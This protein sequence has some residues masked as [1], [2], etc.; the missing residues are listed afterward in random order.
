MSMMIDWMIRS[1]RILWAFNIKY[2]IIK[3]GQEL[4]TRRKPAYG[5]GAGRIGGH[6]VPANSP[7]RLNL[8]ERFET[9][10]AIEKQKADKKKADAVCVL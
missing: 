3:T 9:E 5:V 2:P 6:F 4:P 8:L 7:V 10:Q 1:C